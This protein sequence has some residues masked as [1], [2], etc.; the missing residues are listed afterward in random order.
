MAINLKRKVGTEM[1]ALNIRDGINDFKTV[2]EQRRS[3]LRTAIAQPAHI[4]MLVRGDGPEI[5]AFVDKSA[6]LC[7]E[8]AWQEVIWVMNRAI[9][10]S[11]QE[12][13]FFDK[14][15][16]DNNY[17]AAILNFN[18]VPAAWLKVDDPLDDIFLG[19]LYARASM[20]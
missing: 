5:S 4:I 18:D 6:S 1:R 3:V 16:S 17:C 9:F 11:G 20:L 12:E 2:L 19:F 15:T 13:K 7:S 8:I 14:H 10:E